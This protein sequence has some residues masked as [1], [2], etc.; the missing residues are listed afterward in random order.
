MKGIGRSGDRGRDIRE[1][2]D[3][4]EDIRGAGHREGFIPDLQIS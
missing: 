4:G 2:G 3:Q 1:S